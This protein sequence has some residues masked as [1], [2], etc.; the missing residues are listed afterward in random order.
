MITDRILDISYQSVCSFITHG[1]L[2][3]FV[4]IIKIYLYLHRRSYHQ[5]P[6]L[7][8]KDYCHHRHHYLRCL[9]V[10][11]QLNH[12]DPNDLDRNHQ[13]PLFERSKH[14]NNNPYLL[15]SHMEYN[16]NLCLPKKKK[17]LNIKNTTVSEFHEF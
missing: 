14:Q 9:P 7:R 1:D 11:N 13:S 8:S 10:D 6:S 3:I 12:L 2:H 15:H 4:S 5:Y 17:I 16:N